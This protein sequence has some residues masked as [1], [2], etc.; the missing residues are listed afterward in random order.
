M[1]MRVGI[2]VPMTCVLNLSHRLSTGNL[3]SAIPVD[4]SSAIPY[5]TMTRFSLSIRT[6]VPVFEQYV[7]YWLIL[8][9]LAFMVSVSNT[10]PSKLSGGLKNYKALHI[11]WAVAQSS[12]CPRNAAGWKY[13]TSPDM[14]ECPFALTCMWIT[15]CLRSSPRFPVSLSLVVSEICAINCQMC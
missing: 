12:T 9:L 13:S 2:S 15:T 11:A 7:M 5:L 3:I 8:L 6:G 10:I 4:K 1:H 14:S